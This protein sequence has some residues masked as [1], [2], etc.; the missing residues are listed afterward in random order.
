[1]TSVAVCIATYR[2][3]QGLEWLLTALDSLTF[4]KCPRPNV[5]VVV[6]DNDVEASAAGVCRQLSNRSYKLTYDV[7]PR[8]GI[9]QARNRGVQKVD[10]TVDFI[11]FIDD[12]EI[13]TPQWLDELLHVQ[14]T[15]RADVI[16]GPVLPAFPAAV[17]SWAVKGGF[18]DRARYPTG[19]RSPY[20]GAGN[21]LVRRRVLRETNLVFDE[22]MALTGGEDVLLFSRLTHLGYNTVWADEAIVYET[23]P[24]TRLT[25]GWVLQR[26]YR[27]GNT[28][29]LCERRLNPSASTR[30]VRFGKGVG[31]IVQGILLLPFALLVG[32]HAMVKSA[33]W[34]MLGAGNLS[35]MA[36]VRYEEYRNPHGV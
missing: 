6:I 5:E 34:I 35:G 3:T 20:V 10:E 26:A 25:V 4:T 24:E 36:G 15:T 13:P 11:A 9:P 12:D 29:S 1:M 27:L 8:R 32:P 31:R 7:E 33:R 22:S 18:F 23:V 30:V 2:R 16:S 14:R 19:H 17:P 21:A 28:W